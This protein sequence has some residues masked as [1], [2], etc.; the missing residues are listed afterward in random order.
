M[1]QYESS[2]TA[3]IEMGHRSHNRRIATPLD[4]VSRAVSSLD[5]FDLIVN[6]FPLRMFIRI[7]RVDMDV[8][9]VRR[10][11]DALARHAKG[12]DGIPPACK[13]PRGL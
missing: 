12:S 4:E 6:A 3:K 9:S 13:N 11:L 2:P 7:R 5:R 1:E 8:S 10:P